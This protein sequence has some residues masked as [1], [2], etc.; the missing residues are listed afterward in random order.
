V[1]EFSTIGHKNIV[2]DNSSGLG[3]QLEVLAVSGAPLGTSIYVMGCYYGW[4]VASL[5]TDTRLVVSGM[6]IPTTAG[7]ITKLWYGPQVEVTTV[8]LFGPGAF[9]AAASATVL[10]DA[11]QHVVY[12][13]PPSRIVDVAMWV[14]AYVVDPTSVNVVVNDR[15][16]LAAP[17]EITA[18]TTLYRASAS[19]TWY[20]DRN[21]Q[22][23]PDSFF[24][25]DTTEGIGTEN[26][27]VSITLVVE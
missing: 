7:W 11:G 19:G 9:A 4:G 6:T 15:I 3:G 20:V 24:E 5:V 13:M 22:V 18:A 10:A 23:N 21:T 17:I 16:P 2:E 14:G 27:S 26:L 1:N 25:L 8:K 12:D